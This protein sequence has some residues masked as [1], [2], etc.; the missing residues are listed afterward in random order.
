[1]RHR[2]IALILLLSAPL[3]SERSIHPTKYED[4]EEILENGGVMLLSS[5]IH[6][7]LI[8]Q[9]QET[10]RGRRANFF[11]SIT[12]YGDRPVNLYFESL[13][14]TDQ[15]G[16]PLRIIPKRELI[17]SK[18][19]QTRWNLFASGLVECLEA[20][21]ANNAGD[22]TIHTVT[23]KRERVRYQGDERRGRP[24]NVESAATYTSC[25]VIHNEAERQRALRAVRHEASARNSAI[26]ARQQIFEEDMHSHYFD[27]QTIYPDENFAAN[28]QIEIPKT[29]EKDL[30]FILIH[31][32]LGEER[33][34]FAFYT[35]EL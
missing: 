23:R 21:R 2:L 27:A 19:Q 1:M 34:T 6:D 12:H 7:V 24:I 10:I 33:H 32:D 14:A 5:K 25:G 8:Y 26:V 29:V 20:D 22:T 17:R 13:T 16:R 9:T 3:F 28:F 30:Q 35:K 31:L 11:F 15:M 18:K 4:Q